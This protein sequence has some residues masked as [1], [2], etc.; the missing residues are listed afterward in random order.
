MRFAADVNH[1][2]FTVL[3]PKDMTCNVFLVSPVPS[4]VWRTCCVIQ[5]LRPPRISP[6]FSFAG[7]FSY[8]H[9]RVFLKFLNFLIC[10]LVLNCLFAHTLSSLCDGL[11]VCLQAYPVIFF[12]PIC[13]LKGMGR[14]MQVRRAADHCYFY[15]F[16]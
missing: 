8:V 4:C 13:I 5:V 2:S 14:K 15:Y 16:C 10:Y 11:C 3:R 12:I 1:C 9:C 6:F 7:F